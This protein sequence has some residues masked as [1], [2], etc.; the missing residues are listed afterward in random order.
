MS[1]NSSTARGAMILVLAPGDWATADPATPVFWTGF[2]DHPHGYLQEEGAPNAARFLPPPPDAG[3]LREQADIEAYRSTRALEGGERWAMAHA[4][5]LGHR[6]GSG[7]VLR[8][9]DDV[10]IE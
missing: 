8:S 1:L 5:N 6:A 7:S 2:Q 10:A 9:A 3:S 4:D